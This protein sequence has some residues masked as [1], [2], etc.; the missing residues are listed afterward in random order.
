MINDSPT[1]SQGGG[2][3]KSASCVSSL[4]MVLRKPMQPLFAFLSWYNCLPELIPIAKTGFI[5]V[6]MEIQ[7]MNCPMLHLDK[8][9]IFG[10]A[11]RW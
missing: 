9:S 4:G 5:K 2:L 6:P 10:T 1:S 7:E 3:R 8:E 11:E